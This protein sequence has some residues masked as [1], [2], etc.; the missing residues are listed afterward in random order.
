MTRQTLAGYLQFILDLDLE[1]DPLQQRITVLAAVLCDFFVKEYLLLPWKVDLIK[2]DQ[3][4]V[5][6]DKSQGLRKYIELLCSMYM[7]H[8]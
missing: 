8:F 5:A 1:G 7:R 4:A 3:Q 6:F 2:Y